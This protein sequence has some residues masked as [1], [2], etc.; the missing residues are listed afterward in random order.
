[1]AFYDFA[2]L[3]KEYLGSLLVFKIF[4]CIK[5]KLFKVMAL[6]VMFLISCDFSEYAER[7][8]NCRYQRA[9]GERALK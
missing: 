8:G 7:V 9:V 3:N 5:R 2:L 6:L 4:V 1:L